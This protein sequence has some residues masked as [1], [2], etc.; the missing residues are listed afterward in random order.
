MRRRVKVGIG[1]LALAFIACFV[2]LATAEPDDGLDWI[3]KYGGIEGHKQENFFVVPSTGMNFVRKEAFTVDFTFTKIPPDLM[4]EID[5]RCSL[6]PMKFQRSAYYF[7]SDGQSVNVYEPI[8]MVATPKR[9]AWIRE[10]WSALK[11]RLGFKKE[12]A[13]EIWVK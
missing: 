5:R 12:S 2:F 9:H 11:E 3:R 7:L 6:G 8:V 4:K 10:Q 13:D 1:L